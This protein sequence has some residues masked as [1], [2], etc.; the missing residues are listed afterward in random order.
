VPADRAGEAD[1]N[2]PAGS[3]VSCRESEVRR[4]GHARGRRSHRL[5]DVPGSVRLLRP[6]AQ[7]FGAAKR[8]LCPQQRHPAIARRPEALAADRA[9]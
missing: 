4:R 5:H 3:R 7:R 2:P 9:W 6:G 8:L 1:A